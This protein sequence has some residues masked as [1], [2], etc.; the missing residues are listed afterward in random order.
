MKVLGM[1]NA[2]VDVLAQIEDD[3]ILKSLGLMKGAMILIDENKFHELSAKLN[4]LNKS[5]V[6]GG[7]ASNTIIGLANLGVDTGFIGR[8]GN[9]KFGE[10]YIKD[11][12]KYNVKPHLVEADEVSGVASAF[13]SQDGQRTFGTYL[14]AAAKLSPEDLS[15]EDFKGYD[16]FYIE[17][18]L[19]QSHALIVEAMKMAKDAG[20][21]VAIDL[22]SF[23]IVEE[24]IQFLSTVVP[25]YVDILFA[26]EEEAKVMTGLDAEQAVSEL[27]GMVELAVV[28]IGSAGSWV[29]R[30]SEKVK[31]ETHPIPCLDSTGAGD[32]YAAGYLYG[33][34]NNKSLESCARMG[35][36]LAE[37]VIQVI[38][39]KVP[40]DRWCELKAE[41]A[42]L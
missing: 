3:N 23:N 13:I 34:I 36:L 18:Y 10:L 14:G 33:Y 6:S 20:L 19:V 15:I 41:I 40:D 12:E 26:N 42:K 1:G 37:E 27:A 24:N 21:K 31:I 35:T 8:I 7:S 16:V 30:G 22:A 25:D 28:K 5:I 38:G 32:L 2:L 4:E 39:P 29:Q 17:G 9:D 11:L